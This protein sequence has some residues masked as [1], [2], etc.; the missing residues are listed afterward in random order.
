[1]GL[2]V[3]KRKKLG[4]NMHLNVGKRGASVSMKAGPLSVS[5]RGNA[6]VRLGK[7]VGARKKLW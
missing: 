6:S 1:M 3:R 5:S 4:K 2:F 7:G